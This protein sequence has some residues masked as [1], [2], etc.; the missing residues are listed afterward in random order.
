MV[1]VC[2]QA[3]LHGPRDP[4]AS[5]PG[6]GPVRRD[7][8]RLQGPRWPAGGVRADAVCRQSDGKRRSDVGQ[9]LLVRLVEFLRD[10]ERR[11]PERLRGRT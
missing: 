9:R 11:R 4:G 7:V 10:F 6:Q 5:R 3:G 1:G 8:R 2:P